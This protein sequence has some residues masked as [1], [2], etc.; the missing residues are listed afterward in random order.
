MPLRARA[1]LGVLAALVAAVLLWRFGVLAAATE[2]VLA[3]QRDL[4][5]GL[6]RAVYALMQGDAT[7]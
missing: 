3:L 5:N 4:Q 6:A 7:S 2:V 1:A